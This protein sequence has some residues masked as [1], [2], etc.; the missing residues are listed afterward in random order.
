MIQG[1]VRWN[2]V[3]CSTSAWMAGT[4]WM[5][6]APVPMTGA[7]DDPSPMLRLAVRGW[8]AMAE[9]VSVTWAGDPRPDE[10]AVLTL[11]SDSLAHLVLVAVSGTAMV[12]DLSA[13]TTADH[14]DR[15]I[16]PAGAG[17]LVGSE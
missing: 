9:E 2:R 11:L 14:P 8:V 16:Q 15:P 7:S 17:G 6:E 5:A 1:G 3:R 4:N 10:A 12:P 13:I